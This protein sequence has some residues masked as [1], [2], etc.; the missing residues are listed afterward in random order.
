MSLLSLY[1]GDKGIN[2][3]NAR[4]KGVLNNIEIPASAIFSSDFE[5]KVPADLKIIALLQE[6]FRSNKLDSKEAVL[7]LTGKDLIVR[8]FEMAQLPREELESAINFEAKKYLPFRIEELVTTFQVRAD[9]AK[10]TNLVIFMAI[11]RD[12]LN[13]YISI[14]NQLKFKIRS[15]EYSALSLLRLLKMNKGLESAV[16]AFI[17]IDSEGDE[18]HFMVM[19]NG[20]LLFSRDFTLASLPTDALDIGL[21]DPVLVLQ[22]IKSEIKSSLDYYQRRFS[23]KA[24]VKTV[25]FSDL[26]VRDDLSGFLNELGKGAKFIDLT[27]G[28][29]AQG[30]INS[31]VI[32]SYSAALTNVV[33]IGI[34][35]DLLKKVKTPKQSAESALVL[36]DLSTLIKDIKIDFRMLFLAAFLIAGMYI[37]GL[38]RIQ[39]FKDNLNKTIAGH[40]KIAQ[41]DS[42]ASFEELSNKNSEFKKKLA[43]YDA[44]VKKQVF[45]TKQLN[46][47]PRILPKCAWLT[48]FRFTN[49]D[50]VL[51]LKLHGYAYLGNQQNE[52]VEINK[53]LNDLREDLDFKA[54]FK[55]VTIDSV[56]QQLFDKRD[57]SSFDITCEGVR[58]EK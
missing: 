40:I 19:E 23:Q 21:K 6:A 37:Y 31:G 50:G 44:L 54:Y 8:T 4:G 48:S 55:K 36:P 15:L 39:P 52:I 16:T 57:V 51:V 24:I 10:K 34:K 32:H 58:S 5:D 38:M 33:S 41:I 27:K 25:F 28:L 1:F 30:V 12:T 53:F 3:I 29:K 46:V 20:F 42:N 35:L 18:S 43:I 17:Y 22:K 7:C 11:K 26:A 2:I 56:T 14:S 9:S 13:R 49:I 45:L 47:I